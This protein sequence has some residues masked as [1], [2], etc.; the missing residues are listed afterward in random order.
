MGILDEGIVLVLLPDL[1][2]TQDAAEETP[3]R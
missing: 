3:E 2:L 1:Q